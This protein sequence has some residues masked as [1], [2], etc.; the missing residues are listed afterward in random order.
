MKPAHLADERGSMTMVGTHGCITRRLALAGGAALM[1]ALAACGGSSK[2][3]AKPTST[4]PTSTVAPTTTT[5]ANPVA[6]KAT[7]SSLGFVQA[8]FPAG[9]VGSPHHSDPSDAEVSQKVASCAGASDPSKET[10][11][12]NSPD[13]D[14]GNAEVSS[15]VTVAA[16]RADFE[17]DV[18]SL[19]NAKYA[20][21]VKTIF[22]TQL[23]ADYAKQ[24][25]GVKV[26]PLT[27]TRFAVPAYGEA[28]FGFRLSTKITGPTGISLRFY[29]DEVGYGT[30]RAEVTLTFTNQSAPFD[31][32]LEQSLVAKAAA[33]LKTSAV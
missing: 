7:A 16:S 31:P 23:Q 19:K 22:D 20:T 26:G 21:C 28:S 32:V 14:M 9:W 29:I 27:V 3:A 1:L 15:E 13:F 8:D 11:D 33:K 30:G 24:S 4:K 18:A 6:D 10:A 17:Q 5:V 12:V 2:P 25:P